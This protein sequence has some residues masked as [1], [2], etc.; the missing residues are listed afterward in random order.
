VDDLPAAVRMY[1]DGVPDE[2]VAAAA[3]AGADASSAATG[4]HLERGFPIGFSAVPPGSDRKRYYVFNHIQFIVEYH[5]EATG[6]T[7]GGPGA[8]GADGE[9]PP[10][11]ADLNPAAAVDAAAAAAGAAS[12]SASVPATTAEGSVYRIVGFQ[13]SSRNRHQTHTPAARQRC[14]RCTVTCGH[15]ADG[16]TTCL[17][18]LH[19]ALPPRHAPRACLQVEPF[20]VRHT[21]ADPANSLWAGN[22][23]TCSASRPVTRDA[24]AQLIDD[25]AYASVVYT[26]DVNWVRSTT[27]WADRWDVFIRSSTG[28]GD[29]D[30][31]WFSIINSLMIVIFLTGMIAM[32]L[33]RNLY[34]DIARYNATS[35]SGAASA[36]G[37]LTS[38]AT[39]PKA[40]VAAAAAAAAAEEVAEETGWKLVHGD[41]FRPPAGFF[42]PMFLSVFVG[43]GMQILAMSTV[44]LIFAVLGFL[45]PANQG[46]LLTAFILL[47]VFMGSFAGYFSARLYKM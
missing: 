13:V 29:T 23:A 33:V 35:S 37:G 42:G 44:L 34:R 11:A 36:N 38:A 4:A 30:I 6:N 24:E 25:T 39:A 32:I 18:V 15:H 31:H 28:S 8:A 21:K 12:A 1:E 26:Y 40:D 43:S 46:S 16:P 17:R 41:V 9:F 3:A 2:A 5:E 10:S 14:R 47:F 20:T 27:A 45:S 22:M 7:N 19:T